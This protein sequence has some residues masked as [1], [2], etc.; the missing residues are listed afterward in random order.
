MNSRKA[1]LIFTRN[2]I[3]GKVKT[4]LAKTIGEET[5]LK[6]YL[7]LL[8][9][10]ATVTQNVEA[11]KFVYYAGGQ[12]TEDVWDPDVFVKKDQRGDD[13]GARMY[14]A[15]DEAFQKG[16]HKVIVIGSDL[17]DLDT[18]QLEKAFAA[19]DTHEAV[20]GPAQDGGYYLI[21][22]KK[23]C[24]AIFQNKQWGTSRVLKDTLQDLAHI[25]VALLETR[26]DVDVYEDIKGQEAFRPF[27][28]PIIKHDTK[29][30]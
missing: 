26:N 24:K 4:R 3:K 7:F 9:H 25:K 10:T 29:T 11:D 18:E 15:F 22:L 27:L 30:T 2:P 20:I 14:N 5:A 28:K 23:P 16:Y 19:L 12:P 8:E 1:L 6:V 13:L 17:Y 21:G